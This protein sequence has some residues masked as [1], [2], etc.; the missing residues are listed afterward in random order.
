MMTKRYDPDQKILIIPNGSLGK[1]WILRTEV[2]KKY[3]LKVEKQALED[4]I[5]ELVLEIDAFK[6]CIDDKN[7]VESELRRKI[8][9]RD[10]YLKKIGHW[11][12]FEDYYG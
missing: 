7:D 10:I 12:F 2:D 5:K 3:K 4:K 9:F 6:T 1:S 8:L 11:T